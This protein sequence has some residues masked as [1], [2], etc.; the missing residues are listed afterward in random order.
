[1][2]LV[3]DGPLLLATSPLGLG[4]AAIVSIEFV[5]TLNGTQTNLIRNE[6][7]LIVLALAGGNY[8]DYIRH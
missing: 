6:C 8:Y 2:P 4:A 5:H 3:V 7:P 1:M